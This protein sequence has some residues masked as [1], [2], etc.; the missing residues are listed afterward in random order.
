MRFEYVMAYLL[1]G[2]LAL[3]L[4]G[5]FLVGDHDT[6]NMLLVAMVGWLGGIMS[7]FYT[8]HNPAQPPSDDKQP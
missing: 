6:V 4:L 2:I 8:K 3:A 5:A 7:F 1:T